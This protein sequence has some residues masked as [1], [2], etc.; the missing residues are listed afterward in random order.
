MNNACK[1]FFTLL[2]KEEKNKVE[3][4][5]LEKNPKQNKE[6]LFPP[7]NSLARVMSEV[8]KSLVA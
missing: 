3:F 4:F 5:S 7:K 6:P 2:Y 1:S 8:A